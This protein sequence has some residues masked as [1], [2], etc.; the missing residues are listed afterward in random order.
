MPT[1]LNIATLRRP[2]VLRTS[3]YTVEVQNRSYTMPIYCSVLLFVY[4]VC[5]HQQYKGL[6]TLATKLPKAATNCCGSYTVAKNGNKVAQ[7]GNIVA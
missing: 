7:N 1:T 5:Q 6:S 4:I 3:T 2:I